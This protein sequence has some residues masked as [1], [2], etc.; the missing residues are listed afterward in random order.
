MKGRELPRVHPFSKVN[1]CF[2]RNQHD[3]LN[4]TVARNKLVIDAR[5]E[6]IVEL[7]KI[8]MFM[9]GTSGELREFYVEIPNKGNAIALT[10]DGARTAQLSEEL[11]TQQAGGMLSYAL[12]V[13]FEPV[14]IRKVL[15]TTDPNFQKLLSHVWL[16]RRPSRDQLH[17]RP[18]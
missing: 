8:H 18:R 17:A 3:L 11:H 12:R 2:S 4:R 7:T 6:A 16:Y 5:E 10:F 9:I 15:D 14:L 1:Q 13:P